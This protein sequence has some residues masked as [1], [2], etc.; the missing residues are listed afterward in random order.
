MLR[1]IKNSRGAAVALTVFAVV[2]MLALSPAQAQIA[3]DLDG[4]GIIDDA[5]FQ[6]WLPTGVD[7]NG[8]GL[9][10]GQDFRPHL[11]TSAAANRR[12]E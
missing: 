12:S 1:W 8:D 5:D 2:G 3:G 6:L 10:D 7:A 4:N 9:V 11:R